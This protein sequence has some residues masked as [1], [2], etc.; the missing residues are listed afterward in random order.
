MPE[1]EC[2]TEMP[3]KWERDPKSVIENSVFKEDIIT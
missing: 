1:E 3:R 2:V